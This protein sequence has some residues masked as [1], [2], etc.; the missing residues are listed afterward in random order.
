MTKFLKK[1]NLIRLGPVLT[2]Q[3]EAD[4]YAGDIE[5]IIDIY[6]SCPTYRM[7]EYHTHCGLR[8]RLIPLIEQ[9]E[10]YLRTGSP[11]GVGICGDCWS[12]HHTK[13]AWSEAK[14]P[15]SWRGPV[16]GPPSHMAARKPGTEVCLQQHARLRD[17]F[18]AVDR[19][20]TPKEERGAGLKLGSTT[21]FLKYD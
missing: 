18:M 3:D 16:P 4:A 2:G 7:D 14:R 11:A 21:P 19:D 10:V 15:V 17:M 12:A 6:K 9:L 20:W 13:Y 5:R 8:A 1:N